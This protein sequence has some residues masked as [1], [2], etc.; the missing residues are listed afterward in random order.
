[1]RPGLPEEARVHRPA[2]AAVIRARLPTWAA[3][4]AHNSAASSILWPPGLCLLA[5]G[6]SIDA[7]V[8]RFA[9]SWAAREPVELT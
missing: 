8:E 5:H 2:V 7:D 6:T 9:D 3:S 1:M 4:R